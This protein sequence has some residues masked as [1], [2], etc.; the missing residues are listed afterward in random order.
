MDYTSPELAATWTVADLLSDIEV[1]QETK[2][3]LDNIALR[4][5]LQRATNANKELEE[6]CA[7]LQR[8]VDHNQREIEIHQ[9]A[10][11]Y[12]RGM[13]VDLTCDETTEEEDMDTDTE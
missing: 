12:A 9:C 2:L 13:F 11:A 7:E 4:D 6:K 8:K 3:I 10:L 5:L 1:N